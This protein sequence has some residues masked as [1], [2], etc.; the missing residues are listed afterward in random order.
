MMEPHCTCASSTHLRA[1]VSLF[2]QLCLVKKKTEFSSIEETKTSLSNGGGIINLYH[3]ETTLLC[4]LSSAGHMF[5]FAP[6]C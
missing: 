3:D 5:L 4:M 2:S 6:L 1:H